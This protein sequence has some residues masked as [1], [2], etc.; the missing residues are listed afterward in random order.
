MKCHRSAILKKKKKLDV[1]SWINLVQ[2]EGMQL[3]HLTFTL[4]TTQGI[5]RSSQ[6]YVHSFLS[7]GLFLAITSN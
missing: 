7:C 6:K 4:L 5:F 3:R 2:L 1:C